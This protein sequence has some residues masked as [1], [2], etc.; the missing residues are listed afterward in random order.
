[1]RTFDWQTCLNHKTQSECRWLTKLTGR[2]PHSR[3]GENADAV[4]VMMLTVVTSV[5]SEPKSPNAICAASLG[6]AGRERFAAMRA[7]QMSWL[8]PMRLH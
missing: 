3:R 4:R 1:M 8:A 6:G 2:S 5:A 7:W